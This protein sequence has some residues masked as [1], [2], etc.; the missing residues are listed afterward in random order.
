ME[1]YEVQQL[2]S[3]ADQFQITE[4]VSALEEATIC[5]LSLGACGEA[6][7]W[8]RGC[9]MRRLEAEA[10]KMAVELFEEFARTEGFMQMGWERYWGVYWTT[11]LG[12]GRY[13]FFHK[14]CVFRP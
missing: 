9:G 5:Q 2:A 1:L 7:S 8:S 12:T 6:L 14:K 4:V 10:L 3:V 13:F 11:V